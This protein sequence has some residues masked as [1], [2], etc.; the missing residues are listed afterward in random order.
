MLHF[1]SEPFI[2]NLFG[3][4]ERESSLA[5]FMVTLLGFLVKRLATVLMELWLVFF[6]VVLVFPMDSMSSATRCFAFKRLNHQLTSTK[7][8]IFPR[9]FSTFLTFWCKIR[10]NRNEASLYP[11]L[12]VAVSTPDRLYSDDTIFC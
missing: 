2:L 11:C 7:A 4:W 5:M 12:A 6:E 3:L 9:R 8:W 1:L 10:S